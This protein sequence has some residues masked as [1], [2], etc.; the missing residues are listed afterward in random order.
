MCGRAENR[1]I[2]APSGG[3]YKECKKCGA[4]LPLADFY[5]C[6]GKAASYCK[7]CHTQVGS[8]NRRKR[9]LAN[10]DRHGTKV[11]A[12]NLK[13][14]FG[15]SI[16]DY[17]RL[18]ARQSGR[19]AICNIHQSRLKKRLAVDHDHQTGAVRGLLCAPCNMGIGQLGD[20]PAR[21]R[22]AAIYLD[23]HSSKDP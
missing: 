22:S 23:H 9:A 6:K 2:S 15:I 4:A 12:D 18:Y 7:S 1:M 5:V 20:D 14:S 3:C 13:R 19:C 21:L 11:R 17:D 16:E 8:E 10:P